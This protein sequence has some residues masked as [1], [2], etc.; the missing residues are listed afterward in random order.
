MGSVHAGVVL[1]GRNS[2]NA[3]KA[4][5]QTLPWVRLET[6]GGIVTNPTP[7]PMRIASISATPFIPA[8]KSLRFLVILALHA[9]IVI[10]NLQG[11]DTRSR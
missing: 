4:I 7:A 6:G 8:M 9:R 1:G 10:M 11:D 3:S 2:S 5:G